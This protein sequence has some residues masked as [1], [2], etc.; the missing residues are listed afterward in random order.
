M[1]AASVS[2]SSRRS[3]VLE[4]VD[5]GVRCA[6]EN[7]SPGETRTPVHALEQLIDGAQALEAM[8]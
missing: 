7:A 6:D 3:G 2:R 4:E 5:E 8:G 1:S